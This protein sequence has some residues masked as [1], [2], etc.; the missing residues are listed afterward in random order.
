MLAVG[1]GCRKAMVG[2]VW[3]IPL[4]LCTNKLTKRFSHLVVA[5]F[6]AL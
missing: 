3:A 6:L 4:F 5:A 2:T 1:L